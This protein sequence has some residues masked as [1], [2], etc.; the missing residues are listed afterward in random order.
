MIDLIH[1]VITM[2]DGSPNRSETFKLSDLSACYVDIEGQEHL[3][4]FMN[5]RSENNFMKVIQKYLPVQK[6]E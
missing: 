2:R 3:L 1:A 6:E 5:K 4:L